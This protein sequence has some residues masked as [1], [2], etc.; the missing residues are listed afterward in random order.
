MRRRTGSMKQE[1]TKDEEKLLSKP[2]LWESR[3]DYRRGS[4]M[5]F[6]PCLDWG[7]GGRKLGLGGKLSPKHVVK[8]DQKVE[9]DADSLM[10]EKEGAGKLPTEGK[11]Q[12]QREPIE[13]E[14][15]NYHEW[16]NFTNFQN[17]YGS[18]NWGTA[19]TPPRHKGS[20]AK[21]GNRIR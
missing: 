4:P 18:N 15:G 7:K 8:M 3:V 10:T 6:P 13:A 20:F 2:Y 1:E 16:C 21:G 11:G 19:T 12:K 14:W 5:Y 17:W 9:R